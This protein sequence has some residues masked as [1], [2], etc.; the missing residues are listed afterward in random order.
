[1]QS[2]PKFL[3][4]LMGLPQIL[5]PA[6]RN[7]CYRVNPTRRFL[8]AYDTLVLTTLRRISYLLGEALA[9]MIF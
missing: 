4:T 1:M 2:Y 6:K 7:Y 8:C 9:K 3:R 5:N